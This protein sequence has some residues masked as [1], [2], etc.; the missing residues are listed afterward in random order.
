MRKMIILIISIVITLVGTALIGV[1]DYNVWYNP[2]GKNATQLQADY[3]SYLVEKTVEIKDKTNLEK[4]ESRIKL[5]RQ[6]E[7]YLYSKEPIYTETKTHNGVELFKIAV[8]KNVFW[9][10]NSSNEKELDHYRYEVFIYNVNYVEIKNMFKEMRVPEDPTIIDKANDPKFVVNFYPYAKNDGAY[11]VDEALIN[12]STYNSTYI[13]SLYDGEELIG[14]TMGN[15]STLNLFDYGSNPQKNKN[16]EVYYVRSFV[17]YDYTFTENVKLF[18]GG[19]IK[20]DALLETT[21]SGTTYNY[22][23]DES[24]IDAEIKGFTF[25]RDEIK[26]SDYVQGFATDQGSRALLNSVDLDGV[27]SYDG[28]VFTRYLWWQCLIAFIAC[29]LLMTGFYFTFTYEEKGTTKIKR[30][31]TKKK[32]K[33]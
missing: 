15:S 27:L 2:E 9:K 11:N 6:L 16:D 25:N 17:F 33:K 18:E 12:D 7:N 21:Q 4:T 28:W 23:L 29:G 5:Y 26:E 30:K 13:T 31:N 10:V 19:F 20:V 8:Y 32:N 1:Y 3:K 22:K 24:L 14:Y